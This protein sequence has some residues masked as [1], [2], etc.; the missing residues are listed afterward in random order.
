M[1]EFVDFK[2]GISCRNVIKCKKSKDTEVFTFPIFMRLHNY[3][4]IDRLLYSTTV[5]SIPQ[6][7]GKEI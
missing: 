4:L 3:V 7:A 2:I 5:Q 1:S 6:P